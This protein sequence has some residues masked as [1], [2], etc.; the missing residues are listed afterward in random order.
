[1]HS[2]A[3]KQTPT[4]PLDISLIPERLTRKS[5]IS[6]KSNPISLHGPTPSLHNAQHTGNSINIKLFPKPLP[7]EPKHTDHS[8]RISN[9][10]AIAQTGIYCHSVSGDTPHEFQA[11]GLSHTIHRTYKWT[12]RLSPLELLSH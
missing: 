10:R 4:P 1:M 8:L 11:T 7:E 9:P 6:P 3:K 2:I 12:R 5:S